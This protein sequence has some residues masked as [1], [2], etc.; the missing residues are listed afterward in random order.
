M[1]VNFSTSSSEPP[2]G[3][4]L[5][6]YL[7]L[8]LVMTTVLAA[9]NAL[10]DPYG[11]FGAPLIDG[12]NRFKF[13][14][15]HHQRIA[16]TY[17]LERHL[18]AT[19]ILGSSR[20]ASALDPEHPAFRHRPVYNLGIDASSI[21]EVYRMAQHAQALRPLDEMVLAVDFY[22][23]NADWPSQ[24]DFDESRLAVSVDGKPTHNRI[25]EFASLLASGD[26]SYESWWSLRHQRDRDTHYTSLGRRDEN[27]D[28]LDMLNRGGQRLVF[29]ASEKSYVNY[30]YSPQHHGYLLADKE[31]RSPFIWLRRLLDDCR[32]R[33]TRVHLVI[34]PVHARQYEV[35][36]AVGLWPA[37]P[38]WKRRVLATTLEEAAAHRSAPYP[39][40]DFGVINDITT[41]TVPALGDRTTTMR[42][43]RESSHY[44]KV[45]G[46]RMLDRIL[47]EPPPNDA[48]ADGFGLLLTTANIEAQLSLQARRF[49]EWQA[50]HPAEVA[51]IEEFAK[52]YRH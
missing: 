50:G 51:E 8:A 27:N 43:Y 25:A 32:A 38:D 42:W 37:Y 2:F 33:G 6:T 26:V 1:S 7:L 34:N 23:F 4:Y 28:E 18:P 12:F 39:V 52:S 35:M 31:G 19:V 14:F 40:W 36:A 13:G 21:Y 24:V 16:K 22:M 48:P 17:A 29:Q 20:V 15:N 46:D 44:R 30:G 47:A 5:A 49:A 3:R 11:A 45:L 41:E 9:F 10:V